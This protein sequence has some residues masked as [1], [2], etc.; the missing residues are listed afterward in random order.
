MSE[1]K[2]ISNKSRYRQIQKVKRLINLE[3]QLK[4]NIKKRKKSIKK[5][6]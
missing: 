3:K 5:N 6:G 1:T 2:K 4:A